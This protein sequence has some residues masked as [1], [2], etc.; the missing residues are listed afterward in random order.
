MYSRGSDNGYFEYRVRYASWTEA[1]NWRC[2]WRMHST[3][4]TI[5]GGFVDGIFITGRGEWINM[6][7][8]ADRRTIAIPHWQGETC[9]TDHFY[10]LLSTPRAYNNSYQ[11]AGD[12]DAHLYR[13]RIV[14]TARFLGGDETVMDI[15]P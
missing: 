7:F 4:I 5:K 9:S 8:T 12:R 13:L 2:R 10:V 1:K 15:A 3:E 14:A 11:G 6:H